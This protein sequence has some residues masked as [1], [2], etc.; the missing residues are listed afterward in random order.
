MNSKRPS[1]KLIKVHIPDIQPLPVKSRSEMGKVTLYLE[2]G[3]ELTFVGL[4]YG[5]EHTVSGPDFSATI[6]LD[7]YNQRIRILDYT[8]PNYSEMI[9]SIRRLAEANA[10]D[11]IICYAKTNDWQQFLQ[12]GYVLEAVLKYYFAG[13]DAY[14]VSKFRSQA[15]VTSGSLLEEILLIEDIMSRPFETTS[16][17]LPEG[18]DLRL[19]RP[20]D[21]PHLT[22][23]YRTIFESYPSPL[24]HE[25]YMRTVF[26]KES[27]FAVITRED[28]IIAAASAELRPKKLTAELTDCATVKSE[29]GKGLM[30]LILSFLENELRSRDY[31]SA[32]TLARSRSFGMNQVFYGLEYEFLGRL[33]NNCDIYGAYEDM[34]LWVKKLDKSNTSGRGDA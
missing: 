6:F 1:E 22:K 30:S 14:V 7:H 19:A 12:H 16:R 25:D 3:K 31:R 32:Y 29:R 10:F 2:P 17:S 21:I 23:L 34:N 20:D 13:E 4:V 5:V 24:M 26:E 11:K 27:V 18:Y 15:R 28:T 33:V 9:L 8:G